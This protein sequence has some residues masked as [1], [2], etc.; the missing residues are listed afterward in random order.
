M[1]LFAMASDN[2][3]SLAWRAQELR[4]SNAGD[5]HALERMDRFVQ[6]VQ[7]D[8]RIGVNMRPWVL[9]GFLSRGVYT[10]IYGWAAEMADLSGG[11][12]EDLVGRKLGAYREKRHL[13]DSAFEDSER[14][15]Y[16]ALTIGGAGAEHY[17]EFCFVARQTFAA[18]ARS[19]A[20]LR[21][22]SLNHYVSVDGALLETKMGQ[23]LAT[24]SHRH[25]LALLKHAPE[26]QD[27]AD[28]AAMLCSSSGYIEAIFLSK[29]VPED[30]EKVWVSA[31]A[32]RELWELTFDSFGRGLGAGEKAMQAHFVEI[33]RGLRDRSLP[34][35]EVSSC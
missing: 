23:D 35:E 14:F 25:C 10:N 17:G 29:L 9:A 15:G 3:E 11:D 21:D 22:D 33:L 31:T 27:T 5:S 7:T 24:P 1:N 32:F 8:G 19:C 2:E 4:E 20:Y 30:G 16:G 12:P 18:D 34:Y 28:W 6:R 26:L 13:F